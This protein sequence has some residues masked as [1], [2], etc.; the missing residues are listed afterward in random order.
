MSKNIEINY[1]DDA[2]Y[3]P[4]YPK[5]K[6]DVNYLSSAINTLYGFTGE[7]SLDDA[8][9][10]L[11]LGVG[12]Y[13]YAIHVEYP[14]GSPAEGFTVTGIDHPDGSSAVVTD[15]NGDTVGVSSESKVTVNIESPYVDFKD[16]TGVEITATGILTNHTVI[17]QAGIVTLSE[18]NTYTFSPLAK[19]ADF[20]LVGGGGPG[21]MTY[22]TGGGGGYVTNVMDIT[23]T[24]FQITVNI[25]SGGIGNT[26]QY[27]EP[28]AGGMT[29]L[30]YNGTLNS[31]ANGG[32]YGKET[33]QL[34]YNGIP[35][36]YTKG[37]TG[38]GDGGNQILEI[39]LSGDSS[40][41][42]LA[43][44]HDG[45]V[46]LFNDESLGL[47]GGG[48]GGA[49]KAYDSSWRSGITNSIPGLPNGGTGAYYYGGTY[50]SVPEDGTAEDGKFPGGGGGCSRAKGYNGAQGAVYIR[51]YY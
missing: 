31:T 35:H 33:Y 37:G 25:G 45:T 3:E 11:F 14:D 13:G 4:L 41:E 27:A 32:D 2:G 38:N 18:S 44:G 30:T 49:H 5:T 21:R 6:T 8:L 9:A 36:N 16:V 48:G 12:K 19:K 24:S 47:A 34:I 26:A 40:Y 46:Y 17:L 39:R 15:A 10:Q 7:N 42:Y 51:T 1:K 50:V 28:S 29:S 23:L 20:C 43:N 22:N